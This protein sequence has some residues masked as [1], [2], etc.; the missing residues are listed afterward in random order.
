MIL[1]VI[2]NIIFIIICKTEADMPRWKLD[3]EIRESD[4][5]IF[6]QIKDIAIDSNNSIYVLDGKDCVIYKYDENGKILKRIGRPGQGPGEFG[7]PCSIFVNSKDWIYV[8]DRN[9]RKVEVFDAESKYRE[10]IKII[11][12]PLGNRKNVLS[13]SEGNIY[14]TGYF[15]DNNTILAKYKNSGEIIKFYDLPITEYEKNRFGSYDNIMTN[16]YLVGGNVCLDEEG[17]LF[18]SY[19]WPYIIKKIYKNGNIVSNTACKSE[20]NW[21]PFIFRTDRENGLLFQESTHSAKIF[22]INKD[23][24]VNSVY[25][26]D[27]IGN[28]NKVVKIADA[29][30]KPE[31]YFKFKGDYTSIDIY[32][33]NL[34]CVDKIVI[35]EKVHI[36][37]ADK[38]GKIIGIRLNAEDIP[39][40]VRYNIDLNK[41]K[42]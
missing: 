28:P 12:M 33:K 39:S 10:T 29:Q 8:L 25:V 14:I 24:I 26:H 38:K 19:S 36:Y 22:F 31:K 23:L 9:N 2:I 27:W 20:Y 3:I 42:Y 11:V 17:N 32:D 21:T 7:S 37:C 1:K 41:A 4:N 6:Q 16:Q 40:I 34:K 18:C 15:K 13:D 30:M 35:K 5:I